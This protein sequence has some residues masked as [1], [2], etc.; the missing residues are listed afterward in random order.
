MHFK[1]SDPFVNWANVPYREHT[2]LN[3]VS[4]KFKCS[5][6]DSFIWAVLCSWNYVKPDTRPV[7]I[8][9][10]FWL[11]FRQS[12]DL[13]HLSSLNYSCHSLTYVDA[14]P[15]VSVYVHTQP[16][17]NFPLLNSHNSHTSREMGVCG[18]VVSLVIYLHYSGWGHGDESDR[19]APQACVWE[20]VYM[21]ICA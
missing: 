15:S 17:P 20:G 16:S 14:L 18:E 13:R 11:G 7:K 8:F 3:P 1:C 6:R 21:N 12:L 9:L 5:K 10:S 4:K 19:H 2:I